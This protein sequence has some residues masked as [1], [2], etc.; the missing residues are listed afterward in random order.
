MIAN[1]RRNNNQS[2]TPLWRIF[3]QTYEGMPLTFTSPSL[4]E[5]EEARH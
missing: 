4:M 2:S 1:L 3:K 5:G